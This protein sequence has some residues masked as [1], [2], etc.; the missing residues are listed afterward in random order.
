MFLKEV[1]H[2]QHCFRHGKKKNLFLPHNTDFFAME[3]KTNKKVIVTLYL[4]ILT[5]FL[6]VAS[7][8]L[9]ISTYIHVVINL[10]LWVHILTFF[11]ELHETKLWHTFSVL[12]ENF[13][14]Y[15]KQSHLFFFFILWQKQAFIAQQGCSNWIQITAKTVLLRCYYN[16]K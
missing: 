4:T 16:L 9:K 6:T 11:S 13:Y 10:Q 7:L 5:F 8:Y 15:E 3:L 1:C 14:N 12:Q 2:A